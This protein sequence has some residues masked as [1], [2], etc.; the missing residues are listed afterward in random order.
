MW[1]QLGREQK[2]GGKISGWF[3]FRQDHKHELELRKRTVIK[4][5]NDWQNEGRTPALGGIYKLGESL[6][7]E[8]R[9]RTRVIVHLNNSRYIKIEGNCVR[10]LNSRSSSRDELYL[11]VNVEVPRPNLINSH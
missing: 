10:E 4:Q 11:W 2:V 6:Q 5:E 8:L 7:Q 3:I 9:K 1:S